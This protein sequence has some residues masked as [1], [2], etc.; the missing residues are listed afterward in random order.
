MVYV[1]DVE[2][3]DKIMAVNLRGPM[4]AYKYAG[5]QMIKQGRGG[6]LISKPRREM[7]DFHCSY[8]DSATARLF[9]LLSCFVDIGKAR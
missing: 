3:W 8:P 7:F 4:L 5:R 6:R 2:K 9:A 1:V